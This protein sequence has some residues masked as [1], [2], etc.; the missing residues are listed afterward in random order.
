MDILRDVKENKDKLMLAVLLV[1][2]GVL[3]RILLHD[4]FYS[5]IN[6][7]STGGYPL[8]LD[9][10]FAV[11]AVSVFSGVLL[12]KYYTF[13]VPVCVIGIT[14]IFYALVDPVNAASWL[15]WLFLFTW[16]GYVVLALTGYLTRRKSEI[17][18]LFI[19]KILGTSALGIVFYDL[20]SN[21]GF[22]LAYSKLGFYPQNLD[23][24]AMVYIGGIPSMIWHLLSTT[25]VIVFVAIP[26]VY[27]REQEIIKKSLVLKP[28]EKYVIASATVILMTASVLTVLF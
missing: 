20:W 12:G 21:F 11:A 14:D 8:P 16:S 9:V 4:F 19:P 25:L 13:V 28:V 17:N 23:G 3:S 6:P 2:V 7:I 1:A 27:L 26:L 22:W 18:R 5:I 10:F 15:T 24:L